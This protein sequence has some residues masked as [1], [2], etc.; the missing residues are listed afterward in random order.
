MGNL[1]PTKSH[2]VQGRPRDN[3]GMTFLR[4]AFFVLGG[5][6]FA[7]GVAGG[8]GAKSFGLGVLFAAFLGIPL[9]L[10]LLKLPQKWMVQQAAE[11]GDK[12]LYRRYTS[13]DYI[14]LA[15]MAGGV[16]PVLWLVPLLPASLAK[17]L[18]TPAVIAGALLA[19]ASNAYSWQLKASLQRSVRSNIIGYGMVMLFGILIALDSNELGSGGGIYGFSLS[20]IGFWGIAR[21]GVLG[22]QTR[23]EPAVVGAKPAVSAAGMSA[24]A[25]GGR[26]A[27]PAVK[28]AVYR[29]LPVTM[30]IIVVLA[31]VFT[32]EVLANIGSLG[33]M[34]SPS[35][36]TLIAF[37]GLYHQQITQAKEWYR[38]LAPALLHASLVHLFFN[39]YALFLIGMM[40]ENFVGRAWFL[41]IFVLGSVGGALMSLAI[42]PPELVSVGAS[43]AI[44]ALFAAALATS[45]RRADPAARKALQ[46]WLIQVLILS[47]LPV[48]NLGG[49]HIDIAAHL[50]G[51]LVGS[52]VGLILWAIWD[53]ATRKPRFR[54]LAIAISG[55]G[56]AGFA[57]AAVPAMQHYPEYVAD[58][59]LHPEPVAQ[60]PEDR[61]KAEEAL[62]AAQQ[63]YA[64][65]TGK[66]AP[67]DYR[68]AF[69]WY[70]KGAEGGNAYAEG[71]LSR[72]YTNG[73]GTAQDYGQSRQWAEKAVLQ[74]DAYAEFQMGY[75]YAN[76]LGV[77]RDYAQALAWFNKSAAQGGSNAELALGEMYIHGFGVTQ[78]AARGF[79][80]VQK[81]AQQGDPQS[82][83]Y[84]VYLYEHGVGVAADPDAAMNWYA[85]AAK[86]GSDSAA[87]ALARLRAA[88]S[89]G[90]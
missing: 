64:Y 62:A 18:G 19:L 46:K 69:Q 66:G 56:L 63:G 3:G 71:A 82:Q 88:G 25:A 13:L 57:Y 75:F 14:M 52:V 90:G 44:M 85:S 68:Q 39:C 78:D 61:R 23:R 26:A 59:K 15:A 77:K 7:F 87:A 11:Q 34:L 47:L 42:N 41:A 12:G 89:S 16:L 51:A 21:A 80:W 10:A 33:P 1:D 81:A 48:F 2:M 35:L 38:L 6:G 30:G 4:L 32:L 86:Q 76:G 43:G 40:L 79:Q 74:G 54:D 70:S 20:Y 27:V 73:Q 29:S 60:S 17:G 83:E 36:H 8:I 24:T 9:W 55:L 45:F 84:L 28:Q 5:V 53:P 22:M 49:G 58:A 37:G 65:E 50:G 72:L 31:A 67:Q